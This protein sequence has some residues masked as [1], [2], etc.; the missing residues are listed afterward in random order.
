MY[1]VSSRAV[2]RKIGSGLVTL[3]LL[4][5]GV[6]ASPAMAQ[7]AGTGAISGTVTDSTGAVV[8]GATVIA[9]AN[10]TNAKTVRQTTGAGDYNITPLTPG[11]YTV[12]VTA[13]G[14]QRLVQQNINVNALQTVALN[15]QL[16]IG[17]TNETVTVSTAP[18]QLQ[19]TDATLGG[20]MENDMYSALPLQMSQGGSGTPDQRRATDFEYLMPGVQSNYTS[21]NSTDNSGIVNGSGSGGGVSEIY[22]DGVAFTAGSQQG[23]PRFYVDRHRRGRGESVSG[24]DGWIF[25]AVPRPGRGKLLHQDRWK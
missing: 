18:P 25:G 1:G 7:L 3:L 19:T 15:P 12:V 21:N 20:V 23:D 11:M 10:D 24:S 5:F 8:S 4:V 9:T 14:F 2:L 13:K 17:Q 6:A 16:T 22:I